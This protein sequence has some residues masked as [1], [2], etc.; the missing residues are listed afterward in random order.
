MI[1]LKLIL[2]VALMQSANAGLAGVSAP[3]PSGGGSPPSYKT[4]GTASVQC[5]TASSCATSAAVS[6]STNDVAYI[7]VTHG[8]TTTCPQ[9]SDTLSDSA[10][11]FTFSSTSYCVGNGSAGIMEVFVAKATGSNAGVTF[12][13][14]FPANRNTPMVMPLIFTG[15]TTA[16]DGG[17]HTNGSV[18]VSGTPS[19]FTLSSISTSN[20]KD[21]LILCG[22][23]DTNTTSFSVGT[24]GGVT[25]SAVFSQVNN[26]GAFALGCEYLP[27]SSVQSSISATI[28][29]N[30]LNSTGNGL[31]M[32][33]AL[34]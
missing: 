28:I 3:A 34:E 23:G 14:G 1:F 31:A 24:F 10:G 32:F 17:V 8:T 30:S 16:I 21:M 27:V 25:A 18:G 12:T 22:Q 13:A 7:V 26:H 29:A 20:A 11:V 2:G 6:I 9:S 19:T 5:A 4:G 15:A 33:G